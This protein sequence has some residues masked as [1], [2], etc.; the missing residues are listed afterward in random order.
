MGST[1][2]EFL[3]TDDATEPGVAH[4]L[5]ALS[6]RREAFEYTR[7][8]RRYDVV[9]DPLSGD[10]GQIV[11]CV[12][13]AIDI[14][15]LTESRERLR[16]SV[17]LLEATLQA[18]ADGILVVDDQGSVS[19]FNSRF[20][21]LWRLS[22]SRVERR[23]DRALLSYMSSQLADPDAFLAGVR[24]L[25]ASPERESADLLHF[26]DGRV[27]ERSS[28]PQ[29]VGSQIV[30][31]VWSFR[32]VTLRHRLLARATFL[33]D[34]GRIL[35]SL[36]LGQALQ[37]MAD[38]SVSYLGERCAIDLTFDGAPRRWGAARPGAAHEPDLHPS[39]L[40][41][42]PLIYTARDRAHMATPLLSRNE[43]LGVMTIVGPPARTYETDDL[44]F[45]SEVARRVA[46]SIDNVRLHAGAR[47]TLAS[48]DEFLSIAAH[49]IRGPLTSLHLA[50]Q[51]L[52]RGSLPEAG[53]KTAL[54]IV[55]REDRRLRRFV[56]ELLDLGRIRT[57]QLHLT[58]EDVDLGSIIRDTVSRL[59]QD[60]AEK[61]VAVHLK[62]SGPLLGQWDRFRL[63]QVVNIL[64]LNAIKYG[65]GRPIEL[66]AIGADDHVVFTC[67][68]HGIGIPPT[69]LDTIFAPYQRAAEARIFGGLGL[70]LHIAKKVVAGLGG[71]IVANNP[72]G[73]GAAFTVELPFTRS[74]DL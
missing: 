56:D 23:D 66:T 7:L 29:R 57:G 10:D 70:G 12:G 60:I 68:D 74:H 59:S 9:I 19:N 2:Y 54:E 1:I 48:R 30:G 47:E 18:T 6:G 37:S 61:G 71:T 72:P 17:S 52:L 8:G 32:D 16:E 67:R 20:L 39:V 22:R 13:A 27:F 41:G 33:A 28:L 36:D 64:L 14:S 69:M 46:L 50:V 44:E 25:Y 4:H 45:L 24:D 73:G 42:H 62:T 40:A 3:G 51:S 15:E 35:A 5:A 38:L 49:E 63:E 65:E 26:V 34:T 11:G 55:E 31:R 53:V 58:I 43:V 21:S